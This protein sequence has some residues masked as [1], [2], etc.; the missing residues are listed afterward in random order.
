MERSIAVAIKEA[1]LIGCCLL[2]N[3]LMVRCSTQI[4]G[5]E[6][7]N[8]CTVVATA[9]AIEGS[10]PP[11]SRVFI[12]DTSYIPYI[13][14]GI[15]IGTAADEEGAFHFNTSPGSYHLFIVEPAG[16]SAG[17]AIKSPDSRTGG[18]VSKEQLL[19]KPGAV[20]G[21]ISSATSDTFLVFLEGM[22]HYQV[23][24]AAQTFYLKNVPEGTYRLKIARLSGPWN[25]G[26]VKILYEQQIRVSPKETVEIGDIRF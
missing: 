16:N 14:S 18:A 10:A 13:D 24:T 21:T 25:E 22:C 7:T 2:I 15:G 20:S 3:L 11:M 12:F 4:A 1:L 26:V 17:I 8:G 6:T 19:Q 5:V 9:T 23:V